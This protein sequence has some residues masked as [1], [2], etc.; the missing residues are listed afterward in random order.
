MFSFIKIQAIN[1]E[2]G[3]TK[4]NSVA[5]LLAESFLIKY[6]KI[7]N[8]PKETANICQPIDNPK[9]SVRLINQFPNA[10]ATIK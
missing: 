6:I 10:R 4:K 9:P 1:T 5:V 3:G 8:A 2:T 7:V